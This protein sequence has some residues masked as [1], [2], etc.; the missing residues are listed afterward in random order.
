M[1]NPRPSDKYDL[2]RVSS[3]LPYVDAIVLEN[4]FA[5]LLREILPKLPDWSHRIAIFSCREI[6]D[7]HGYLKSL[8]DADPEP[9]RV[10]SKRLYGPG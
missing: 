9:Y 8:L 7:Y 2:Q 5:A 10:E 4:H 6:D 3:F 1:K